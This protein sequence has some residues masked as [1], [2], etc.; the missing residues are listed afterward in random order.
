MLATKRQP[1]Q[2]HRHNLL[3]G[4]K[5]DISCASVGRRGGVV[6]LVLEG[7]GH[8][9]FND[10]VQLV[11]VHYRRAVDF[12]RSFKKVRISMQLLQLPYSGIFLL[13]SAANKCSQIEALGLGLCT[14]S[15]RRWPRW[16]PRW[17]CRWSPRRAW[18]S[19]G[20]TWRC[21]RRSGRRWTP[22]CARSRSGW[23]RCGRLRPLPLKRQPFSAPLPERACSCRRTQELRCSGGQCSVCDDCCAASAGTA[24]MAMNRLP[25]N[26][27]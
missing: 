16:S 18:P 13:S 27:S 26:S 3:P 7:S 8:D 25:G 17:R 2:E 22:P 21:R 11:A 24:A 4:T 1:V 10:A 9:T 14:C 19:C 12:L 23:T 6:H 15:T 5:S 20:A